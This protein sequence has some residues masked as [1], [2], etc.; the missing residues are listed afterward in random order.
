MTTQNQTNQPVDSLKI[1]LLEATIWKNQSEK[2]PS[3][4]V[5]ITRRYRDGEEYKTSHSFGSADL[6]T[7]GKLT[8]WAF[9]Q[10]VKQQ[11]ID[12]AVSNTVQRK[13]SRYSSDG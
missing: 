6:A 9:D 2:G 11:F 13:M 10:I 4:S 3:H 8:D 5:T 1:G 12:K 7:V